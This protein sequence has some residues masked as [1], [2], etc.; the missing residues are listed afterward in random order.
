MDIMSNAFALQLGI[1]HNKN[2]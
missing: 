2:T 1:M